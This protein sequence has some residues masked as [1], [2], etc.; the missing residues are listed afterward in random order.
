MKALQA[1]P[2][3]WSAYEKIGKLGENL[4]PNKVF[5]EARMKNLEVNKKPPSPGYNIR[6]RKEEQAES[7]KYKKAAYPTSIPIGGQLVRKKS[8]VTGNSSQIPS[9]QSDYHRHCDF[10]KETSRWTQS[11]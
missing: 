4:M 5:V 7:Q 11:P 10:I 6:K 3:M 8:I 1:N 2:T 9:N